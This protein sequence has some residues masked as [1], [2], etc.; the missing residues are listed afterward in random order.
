MLP[1]SH[2]IDSTGTPELAIGARIGSSF[3]LAEYLQG[4]HTPEN[5]GLGDGGTLEEAYYS[6]PVI[7]WPLTICQETSWLLV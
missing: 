3:L 6:V 1:V 2:V 5:G 4:L 7:R